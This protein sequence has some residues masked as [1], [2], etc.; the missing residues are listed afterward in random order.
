M[1]SPTPPALVYCVTATL[2]D[3]RTADDFVAWLRDG[4]IDAV[5]AGGAAA[6]RVIRLDP[7]ESERPR[8]EVQYLFA[9]RGT[10]ERYEREFAP[11][12]RAEGRERFPPDLGV[13]FDRRAGEVVREW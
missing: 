12:L 6:A 1:T 10:F 2:P 9:S 13:L 5:L 8:V 4:H 7:V 3:G 11:A